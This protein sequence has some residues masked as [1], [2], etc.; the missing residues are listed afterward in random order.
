MARDLPGECYVVRFGPWARNLYLGLPT[1]AT[2]ALISVAAQMPLWLFIP[3]NAMVLLVVWI[4]AFPREV[5]VYPGDRV[6]VVRRVLALI[7]IWRR[8]YPIAA[9]AA[10]KRS[11]VS[12]P[13]S[14]GTT[15]V[16]T[17]YLLLTSGK[18]L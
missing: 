4:C 8:S 7:P 18:F 3:W 13:T 1:A 9:V 15:D 10:I 16:S 5:R 2:F 14:D 11:D 17:V 6:V 12:Y